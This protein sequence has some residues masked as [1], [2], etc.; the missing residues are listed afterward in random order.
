MKNTFQLVLAFVVFLAIG[1]AA[2]VAV[3]TGDYGMPIIIGLCALAMVLIATVG[4]HLPVDMTIISMGIGG[5]YICGKGF[6][7]L[8]AG[9]FLFAGELMLA[10]GTLGYLWRVGKGEFPLIPRT[11]MAIALL[12]LG[13]YALVRLPIDFQEHGIMAMRDSCMIYYTLFFF[14]AYQLGQDEAVKKKSV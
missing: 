10:L 11:P 13:G 4:R 3:G 14:I 9:G 1:L 5:F 7:Y 8:N 6:A 2:A 12:L